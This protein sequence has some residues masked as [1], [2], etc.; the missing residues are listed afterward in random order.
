V[1]ALGLSS[2]VSILLAVTYAQWL[3]G[4]ALRRRGRWGSPS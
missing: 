4:L 1:V 3:V 2:A